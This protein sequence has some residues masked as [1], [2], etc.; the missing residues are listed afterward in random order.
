MTIGGIMTGS[1]TRIMVVTVE[2]PETRP[3]SSSVTSMFRKAGVSSITELAT[4]R[5]MTW[6][7]TMPPMLKMLNGPSSMNGR[8]SSALL[9]SPSSGSSSM[10][11]PSVE[12]MPGTKKA[13]QNMNS[14]P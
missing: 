10:I 3:A 11:Q 8:A 14:R 9:M 12:E 2:A 5:P 4:P 1:V 6:I 13:T 7:H